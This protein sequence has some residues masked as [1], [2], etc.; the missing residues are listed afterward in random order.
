MPAGGGLVIGPGRWL[1]LARAGDYEAAAPYFL[2]AFSAAYG[3]TVKYDAHSDVD[4]FRIEP[5]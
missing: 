5:E 2:A 4:Y 1:G 3:V